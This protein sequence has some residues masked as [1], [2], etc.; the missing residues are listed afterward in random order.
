[1]DWF[2]RAL[3]AVL[4]ICIIIPPIFSALPKS[5]FSN[6]PVSSGDIL[7]SGL[8][9]IVLLFVWRDGVARDRQHHDH[10]RILATTSRRE[11]IQ[12]GV[13]AAANNIY[14]WRENKVE[15][16]AQIFLSKNLGNVD[17]ECIAKWDLF[18]RSPLLKMDS[19]EFRVRFTLF[20]KGAVSNQVE[21]ED[22]SKGAAFSLPQD[23][24]KSD[25]YVHYE[26]RI[27]RFEGE[28]GTFG[29]RGIGTA[30]RMPADI[31]NIICNALASIQ[32]LG[33]DEL[34]VACKDFSN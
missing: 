28:Y 6:G 9:V 31:Y 22:P 15:H 21:V 11:G 32:A 20:P 12:Q 30:E 4:A 10:I 3:F 2:V 33:K 24:F 19:Y 27:H 8:T 7:A 5:V 23:F 17:F 14:S 13:V 25:S 34:N 1:M 18:Y 16:G 29:E 26:V